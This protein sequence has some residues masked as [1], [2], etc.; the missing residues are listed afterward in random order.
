MAADKHEG[1]FCT[2]AEGLN[3]LMDFSFYTSDVC[4]DTARFCDAFH[5]RKIGDVGAD[6]ST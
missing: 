5:E 1:I 3:R 6:R 2:H 4:D